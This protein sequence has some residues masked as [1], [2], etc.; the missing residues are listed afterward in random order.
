MK[1]SVPEFGLPSCLH[2]SIVPVIDLLQA[3]LQPLQFRRPVALHPAN[4]LRHSGFASHDFFALR[5]RR[6]RALQIETQLG[7]L[8]PGRFDEARITLGAG[9]QLSPTGSGG[10]E[11]KRRK[12]GPYAALFGPV[13]GSRLLTGF[14]LPAS[15]RPLPARSASTRMGLASTPPDPECT[16]LAAASALGRRFFLQCQG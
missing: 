1:G 8:G 12:A 16:P 3:T 6:S 2:L 5:R 4:G 7:V 10:Q 13:R 14:G 9:P 11:A 15:F